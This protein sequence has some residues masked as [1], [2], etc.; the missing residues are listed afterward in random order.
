MSVRSVARRAAAA[1]PATPQIAPLF[2]D[3]DDNKLKMIPAGSGTTEVDVVDVSSTQTLTGKTLTSAILNTSQ[4]GGAA[5]TVTSATQL[6]VLK[7][8]I[9]DASATA[10]A[11]VTIPNAA[12]AASIRV[13]V[14]GSMGAGGAVGAFEANSASSYHMSV[15]RTAGVATVITTSSQDTVAASNVAGAG[16][17]TAVITASSVSGGNT[18]TQTF[19]ININITKSGGSSA[20]HQAVLLI[21][22]INANATGITI[23]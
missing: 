21:D 13:L 6:L 15:S 14:L 20:S 23:A 10:V 1:G 11:T 16:T 8:G 9:S 19:T 4:I 5:G 7:T 3:S 2:V 17:I 12:H 18:A 22:L